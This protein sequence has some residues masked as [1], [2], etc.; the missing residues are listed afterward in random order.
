MEFQK[1]YFQTHFNACCQA[2]PL[3][4]PADECLWQIGS[5][6]DLVPFDNRPLA[7]LMLTQSMIPYGGTRLQ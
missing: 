6:I 7:E 2:F 5:G 4:S 1:G 3:N